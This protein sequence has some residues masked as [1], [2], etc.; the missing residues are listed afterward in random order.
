MTNVHV[1]AGNPTPEELAVILALLRPGLR[2][3][4]KPAR[5][6]WGRPVLR[7]SI[8]PGPGVWRHSTR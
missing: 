4:N 6:W 8:A 7:H 3:P 5:S 1:V 2:Q